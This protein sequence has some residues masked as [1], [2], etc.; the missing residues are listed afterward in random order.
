M[1]V[2]CLCTF[3]ESLTS[4]WAVQN[5]SL[6]MFRLWGDALCINRLATSKYPI[7]NIQVIDT[8]TIKDDS[9]LFQSS[10]LRF[11]EEEP[12]S[13][14]HRSQSSDVDKVELPLDRVESNRVHV[15]CSGIRLVLKRGGVLTY[16]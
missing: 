12:D 4:P 2:P 8:G 15:L 9:N 14:Q 13:G 3:R 16:D 7:T 10:S 11:R 5:R 6:D 1:R